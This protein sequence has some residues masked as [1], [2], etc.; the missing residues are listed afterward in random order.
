MAVTVAVP[1]KAMRG[2]HSFGDDHLGADRG[3]ARIRLRQATRNDRQ[4]P[5]RLRAVD[6]DRA[7][8]ERAPVWDANVRGQKDAAARCER[9]I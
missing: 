8:P 7:D 6:C 4:V 3:D 5:R 1:A 2:R 9:G